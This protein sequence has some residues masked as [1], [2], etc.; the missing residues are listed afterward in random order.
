LLLS[1]ALLQ[2]FSNDFTRSLAERRSR[3]ANLAIEER[4][5]CEVST[6]S[7]PGWAASNLVGDIRPGSVY[8]HIDQS[9]GRAASLPGA[10]KAKNAIFAILQKLNRINLVVP[11][12]TTHMWNAAMESMSCKLTALGEHY[13]R[14]VARNLI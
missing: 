9:L 5:L 8:A 2:H 10:D 11:I 3:I 4:G 6:F 14:L 7:P 12:G 13:R 1:P